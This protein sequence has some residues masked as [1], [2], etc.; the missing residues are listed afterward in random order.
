VP[1]QRLS[2]DDVQ[3]IAERLIQS[4]FMR[5]GLLRRNCLLQVDE[6][7]MAKIVDQGYH[8][9]LGARALKRAIERQLAQ[10]VAARLAT[11]KPDAP[12]II[13]ISP[14]REDIAV[15]VQTLVEAAPL[16]MAFNDLSNPKQFLESIEKKL[17]SIEEQAARLQPA[18]PIDA[19]MVLPALTGSV[20][21]KKIGA[22]YSAQ[23][24]A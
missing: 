12:T 9:L 2:R 6:H 13:N 10:P 17:I 21:Q 4:L 3:G 14:Q 8:P 5:E 22:H 16:P 7:A 1:F 20:R 24:P 23:I 15:Y 11:M 18:G 19:A